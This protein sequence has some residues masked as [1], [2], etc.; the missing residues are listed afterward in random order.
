MFGV[1]LDVAIGLVLIYL[2][3]STLVATCTEIVAAV[4]KLRA[5]ALENTIVRL[6]EDPQITPGRFA[7]LSSLFGAQA[8]ALFGAHK[9]ATAAKGD[10]ARSTLSTPGTLKSRAYPAALKA[11]VAAPAAPDAALGPAAL[12][13]L[14]YTAV[15]NHPLV[16]GTQGRGSPA[17]VSSANFCS[18]LLY[19]LRGAATGTIAS[20]VE[21]EVARLPESALK[22]TLETLIRDAQGDLD[23]LRAGIEG[24]FDSAMDRLSGEY[25]RSTQLIAF[26][27]GL[28]VAVACN[29]DSVRIVRQLFAE[30]ATRE[31]LK[32]AANEYVA[33]PPTAN[34]PP[35]KAGTAKDIG[36]NI[37]AASAASARLLTVAPVGWPHAPT[38][39]AAFQSGVAA[40]FDRPT[41]PVFSL[42]GW[43]VTAL[44]GM[45]GAPFWFDTLQ[46]IIN[47]RNTGPKPASTTSASS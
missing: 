17:Y 14:P 39:L 47:I 23:K 16:A 34:P 26:L 22:S 9:N 27:I 25:K 13:A 33:H 38:T 44:A 46:K 11:A 6:I 18:A 29:V 28:G 42:L 19:A 7:R 24:W 37:E 10:P 2:L 36:D 30:P 31:A 4:L 8:F 15:F 32:N 5:A 3:F 45:L 12:A 43:F 1:T 40:W 20:D 41:V 21:G 35:A